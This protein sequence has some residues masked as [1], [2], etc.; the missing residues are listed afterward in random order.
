MECGQNNGCLRDSCQSCN[1]SFS[2]ANC[3]RL[4][5]GRVSPMDKFAGEG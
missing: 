1:G 2:N 3:D 5:Q 4:L